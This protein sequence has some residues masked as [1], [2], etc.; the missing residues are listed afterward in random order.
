MSF[1]TFSFCFIVYSFFGWFYESV[2]CSGLNQKK[3]INRGIGRGPYCPIYGFGIMFMYLISKNISNF[4]IQFLVVMFMSAVYE[5][6]LSVVLEKVYGK[7]VWDYT[8]YPLNLN[9]R[10]CFHVCLLFTGI[11]LNLY[12]WVQ[13]L[14]ERMI[15]SE[16]KGTV[17]VISMV[18]CT[19]MAVDIFSVTFMKY[20][21]SLN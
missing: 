6:I 11:S 16:N 2:L 12:T 3:I 5:Y 15:T 20:K 14:L 7:R 1:T 18:I 21:K 4:I 13:P 10:I 17:L 8:I 9:G 19:F